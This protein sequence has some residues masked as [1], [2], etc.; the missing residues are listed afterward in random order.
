MADV[1]EWEDPPDEIPNRGKYEHLFDELRRNPGRWAVFQRDIKNP[2]GWFDKLRKGLYAGI[3]ENE[4]EIRMARKDRLT[5]IYI[6]I[7]PEGT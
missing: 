6:R 3:E 4:L 5:T 7:P 2:G 1:I